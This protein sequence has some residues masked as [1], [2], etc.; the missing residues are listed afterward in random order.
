MVSKSKKTPAQHGKIDAA[1]FAQQLAVELA[2]QNRRGDL[3]EELAAAIA[4][5]QAEPDESLLNALSAA[6]LKK[7][8]L[9]TDSAL[10][11]YNRAYKTEIRRWIKR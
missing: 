4:V 6:S 11:A 7:L 8:G 1:D 2:E 5:G 3:A 9:S 10:A